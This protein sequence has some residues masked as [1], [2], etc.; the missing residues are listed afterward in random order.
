M[1]NCPWVPRLLPD[2]GLAV[3]RLGLDDHLRVHG[4]VPSALRSGEHDVVGLA[5]EVNLRGRGGAGFP[6]A[7]KARGVRTGRDEHGGAPLVVANGSEGEPASRKDAELL[8]RAPHLV[9]DGLVLAAVAVGAREARLVVGD[10]AARRSAQA[11]LHERRQHDRP[12]KLRGP[13]VRTT[14]VAVQ[15]RFVA[16]E[17]SAVVRASAGKP[18]VPAFSLTRTAAGGVNGRPTLV[19]NVETLAQLAVLARLGVS[20]YRSVGTTDEPGTT[21]LTVHLPGRSDVVEVALGTALTD[22]LGATGRPGAVLVGGYHGGWL[23]GRTAASTVLS[24]AGLDAVGW[25][26]GAGVVVALPD[27]ACPLV[28]AAPVVRFLA[29]E[30]AGQCGPCVHGLA[31]IASAVTAL[32]SGTAGT[33]DV[34]KLR[35]WAGLVAGRGACAHPDGVVRF[36]SSLLGAFPTEVALHQHHACGRLAHGLLPVQPGQALGETA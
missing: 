24:R 16:G 19:S 1:T 20:G 23:A 29:D 26:L 17:S 10:P 18:P 31:A 4:P 33:G 34:A 8:R 30:S 32:A 5:D 28:E 36:V 13:R 21:L 2:P 7:R 14:V 27:S 22:V 3:D 35:R 25:T 11:A 15:D 9:L 6:F 12:W